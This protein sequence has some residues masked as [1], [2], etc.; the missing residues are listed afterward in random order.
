[1]T[2]TIT[3]CTPYG[4]VPGADKREFAMNGP[5]DASKPLS[6]QVFLSYD[7][8]TKIVPIG[9]HA[10]M[11]IAGHLRGYL[12]IK[13]M[14]SQVVKEKERDGNID[15]REAAHWLHSKLSN[16]Y[17]TGNN[18]SG[19]LNFLSDYS[20]SVDPITLVISGYKDKKSTSPETYYVTAPGAIE[21]IKGS[22]ICSGQS[23][24]LERVIT[25]LDP[26]LRHKLL[27]EYNVQKEYLERATQVFNYNFLPEK[28][29]LEKATDFVAK[30]IQL[31]HL[32]GEVAKRDFDKEYLGEINPISYTLD[33]AK[34]EPG[35]GKGFKFL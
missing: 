6:N 34:I 11:T 18:E 33:I 23:H 4:I 21:E 31:T 7:D 20:K 5:R 16:Y 27:T 24:I 12:S 13:S 25:G 28:L 32:I 17:S 8:A 1:M 35:E 29:T 15:V 14:I 2:L 30:I 9:S 3:A 19:K 22:I 10:A 26:I